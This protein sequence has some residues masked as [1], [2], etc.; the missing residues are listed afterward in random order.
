MLTA[1]TAVFLFSLS[2]TLFGPVL[3]I[4]F[5]L[6]LLGNEFIP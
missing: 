3:L 4:L 1:L 6:T 2:W 5:G